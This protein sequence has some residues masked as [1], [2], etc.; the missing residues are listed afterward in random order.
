MDGLD[1]DILFTGLT[2][3]QMLLGV[4]YPF[5]VVNA[6]LTTELFLVFKSVWVLVAALAVHVAGVVACLRDPRIFDLWLVKVQRCPRVRNHR[7]WR[8]NS[9]RA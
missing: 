3:P 6:V 2:R 5:A 9:Y 4:T 7:L 8:C 1:R